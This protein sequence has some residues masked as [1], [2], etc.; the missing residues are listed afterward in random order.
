MIRSREFNEG[1]DK[2]KFL[3]W[4]G[5]DLNEIKEYVSDNL[6]SDGEDYGSGMAV[7]LIDLI[8]KESG[9]MGQQK[10]KKY[11]RINH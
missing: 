1:Q 8:I 9:G 6:E 11:S 5:F 4:C 10:K 7:E 3:V 2:V